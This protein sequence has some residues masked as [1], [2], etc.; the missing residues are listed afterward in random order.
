MEPEYQ[1]RVDIEFSL[2]LPLVNFKA[3]FLKTAKGSF[4]EI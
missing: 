2:L 1:E 4:M 3:D